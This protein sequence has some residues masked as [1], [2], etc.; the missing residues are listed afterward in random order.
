MIVRI[1]GEGQFDVPD[2]AA[3]TLDRLDGLLVDALDEG[4]DDDFAAAQRA[5]VDHVHQSGRP[6]PVEHLGPSELILPGPHATR[7]E[8]VA[9][10]DDG[11]HTGS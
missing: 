8:V 7:A 6:V 1:L 10:L 9:L 4:D 2:D 5:L 11:A 3:P